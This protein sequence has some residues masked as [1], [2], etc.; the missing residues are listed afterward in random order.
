MFRDREDAALRLAEK[1]KGR[2]WHDPLVLAIPRGG[3]VTGAVL[4][5]QL[6]GELDIVLSRKLRAPGQPGLA[7]G[8]VSE[9]GRIYLNRLARG[10][11]GETEN[12]LNAER[13]YQL[14]EIARRRSCFAVS[15]HRRQP[16]A[17]Q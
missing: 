9:D 14:G 17:D 3:V 10:F 7:I 8:A 12:Y 4:A 11:F 13:C 6:G 2:T 15:G 1:L 16:P 5:E